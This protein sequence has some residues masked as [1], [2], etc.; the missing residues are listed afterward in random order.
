MRIGNQINKWDEWIYTILIFPLISPW[1]I[2]LVIRWSKWLSICTM[3]IIIIVDWEDYN[4]WW[5]SCDPFSTGGANFHF[6]KRHPQNP[7]QPHH[8]RASN[9]NQL[10]KWL[11]ASSLSGTYLLKCSHVFCLGQADPGTKK[12]LTLPSNP[13]PNPLVFV[14][15]LILQINPHNKVSLVNLPLFMD[16][17]ARLD[18]VKI[19]LDSWMLKW[20][21]KCI[22]QVK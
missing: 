1:L 11:K 21:F 3:M 20:S 13:N 22:R 19:L 8:N 15:P 14:I 6:C 17:I 16:F 12:P 9:K 10:Y 4:E 7:T 5:I 18:V 2:N